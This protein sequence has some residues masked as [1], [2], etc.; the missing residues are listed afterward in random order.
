[1]LGEGAG[2]C[3][4]PGHHLGQC[5]VQH[6]QCAVAYLRQLGRQGGVLAECIDLCVGACDRAFI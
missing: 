4:R 1:M 5:A 3:G 2:L 6:S